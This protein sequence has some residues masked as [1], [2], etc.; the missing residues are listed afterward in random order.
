MLQTSLCLCVCLLG[1]T[2]L[3]EVTLWGLTYVGSG[4]CVLDGVLIPKVR[5]TLLRGTYAVPS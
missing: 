3:I 1:T 2:E 5:G 4:N